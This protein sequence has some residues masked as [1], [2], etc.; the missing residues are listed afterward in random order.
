MTKI[1]LGGIKILE[2]RSYAGWSCDKTRSALADICSHIGA[3][4][5]NLCQVTHMADDGRGLSS[6]SLCTE[7]AGSFTS[8]FFIKLATGMEPQLRRDTTILSVFPHD[9]RPVVMGALL[10]L[11]GRDDM[12]P[13]ALASSPSAVSVVVPSDN[14][15]A[16]IDSIFGAFEFP[17]YGS[18]LN[19]ETAY[20]G[21]EELF[22]D[23]VGSYEEK[24]IKVYGVLD[25]P[26]LDLWNMVANRADLLQIGTALKEIDTLGAKMPFLLADCIDSQEVVLGFCLPTS[27]RESVRKALDAHAPNIAQ[28]PQDAAGVFFHGPHFGDRYRI[29][30][31]LTGS[32]Q[33]AG[34]QPLALSCAVHSISVILR[35]QDLPRGLEAIKTKFHVPKDNN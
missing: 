26:G 13:L 16:T 11:M 2:G 25:L 18:P 12:Q 32:L 27:Q 6:T 33:S 8:Y 35:A 34:I 7:S 5:I 3:E 17:S 14:M 24:D 1:R 29:A 15:K 28:S 10:E 31:A 22:K 21:K 4:R 19:W 30:G 23:V 9:R 20:V